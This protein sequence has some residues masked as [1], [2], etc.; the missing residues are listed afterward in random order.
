MFVFGLACLALFSLISIGLGN[1]DPRR[2]ANPRDE[3]AWWT[4]FG[5]R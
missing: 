3:L 4:V 2:G 1:E 5:H